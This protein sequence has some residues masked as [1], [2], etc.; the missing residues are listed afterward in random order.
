M[1]IKNFQIM[2]LVFYREWTDYAINLAKQLGVKSIQSDE[3]LGKPLDVKDIDKFK[4]EQIVQLHELYLASKGKESSG[5]E[6]N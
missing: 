3:K 6:K 4:E 1:L 5:E 2:F